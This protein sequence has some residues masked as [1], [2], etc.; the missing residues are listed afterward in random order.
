LMWG[1]SR[2][3][4]LF[5]TGLVL[6][7]IGLLGLTPLA[8]MSARGAVRRFAHAS[9]AVLLAGAAAGLHGA[10]IPFSGRPAAALG[11]RG[12]EHPIAV[13]QAVWLW[14][15]STP[16]VGIEALILGAVGGSLV[17]VARASDLTI[18][19]F[20]GCFL[21]AMLLV[22]PAV[23]AFPLVATGWI[24]YLALTLMSRRQPEREPRS[25]GFRALLRQ[26]RAHFTDRLKPGGGLRWPPR[27]QRF[28]QVGAR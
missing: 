4:L 12:S 16:A 23:A 28:R 25:H 10:D 3:G 5:S 17:L 27:H 6:G 15:E 13:L 11:A 18:A 21:T 8:V 9:A 2:R 19:T 26:T 24:T 1:D 7:P 22:A 20:V 14:L